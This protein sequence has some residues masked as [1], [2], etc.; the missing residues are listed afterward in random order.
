[1]WLVCVFGCTHRACG[2]S[3]NRDQTCATE[4]TT[5]DPQPLRPS[6]NFLTLFDMTCLIQGKVFKSRKLGKRKKKKNS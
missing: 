2:C 3:Q 1:M 6:G 4:M 5:P